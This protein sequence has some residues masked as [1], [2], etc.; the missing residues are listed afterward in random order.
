ML[1]LLR[2]NQ[3]H[4]LYSQSFLMLSI[5]DEVVYTSTW[6]PGPLSQIN[7]LLMK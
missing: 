3:A 2:W 6:I 7:K 1:M 5:D 4:A